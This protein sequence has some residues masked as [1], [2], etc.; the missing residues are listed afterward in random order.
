[1]L[2]QTFILEYV[3]EGFILHE[4]ASLGT[5]GICQMRTTLTRKLVTFAVMDDARLGIMSEMLRENL[6]SEADCKKNCQLTTGCSRLL[7]SGFWRSVAR[8]AQL[9]SRQPSEL[10]ARL[11][12]STG[13]FVTL[14]EL[15]ARNLPPSLSVRL[16]RSW[17]LQR[18]LLSADNNRSTRL[19]K[20][21]RCLGPR[22]R[23]PELDRDSCDLSL[24]AT[25]IFATAVRPGTS[26]NY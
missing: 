22:A 15:E 12:P 14:A 24:T 1:M 3:D 8:T 4:S 21:S 17:L 5:R 26:D 20:R 25:T 6:S 23:F 13:I 18:K 2:N 11:K 7:L 10:P 16:R 19:L 9:V